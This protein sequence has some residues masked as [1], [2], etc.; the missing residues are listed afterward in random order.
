M[1]QSNDKAAAMAS[2]FVNSTNRHVFLTGKAGTGKTTF[3]RDISRLTHKNTIVAAPTGIA[4]IN[5]EGVTLHSLFQLPFGAFIPSDHYQ[6]EQAPAFQLNTPRS[7][8]Q[9]LKMYASKRNLLKKLELLIID[10][11]SMVRADLLDAVD[12]VLRR[13]RRRQDMPFGGV[14]VLFIGD[15]QQLPPV[16]KEAEWQ[17]LKQY[18]PTMFF[19]GAQVLQD[20][21][22]LYIELEKIYR[23]TDKEFIGVLNHLRD[24]QMTQQDVDTLNRYYKPGFSPASGDRY[25]D[26]DGYVYLTT[27]NYKA[28]RVNKDEL[29]KLPAGEFKYNAE[30][31]GTF[32]AHVYPVD[33]VLVL[34]K[35]AQVMF[36]KNDPSGEGQFF[37]GKIGKVE[38][39]ND[40]G[41]KVAFS[42]GA[43]SVWVEKYTWE[44]KRYTLNKKNNE[45]EEKKV[46][47]FVHFPIKLAWAI[48]VHKSQGLT[49]EKAIID[50]SQAFAAGQVYVALSRLTSLKGLVLTSPFRLKD[51]PQDAALQEFAGLKRDTSSLDEQ[52]QSAS[53][54]YLCE[55]VMRAFDFS[56]LRTEFDYHLHTYT[57][58]AGRSEKQ[59]S[60]DW[61]KSIY[62][63]LKP[64]KQVGDKFLKQLNRILQ[65]VS[66]KDYQHL[67]ERVCAAKNY[68]EPIL[69]EFSKK[70]AKHVAELT[71]QK[72]GVKQYIRELQD[73]DLMV[74][75]Q[76]QKIYKSISLI[77][78]FIRD[79]ELTKV[80]VD[81]PPRRDVV[82]TAGVSKKKAKKK[83]KPDTKAVTLQMFN[84]GK[85]I[86]DIAVERSLAVSTIA[87][88]LAW[89]IEQGEID[90]KQLMPQSVIDEILAAFKKLDTIHLS[91]VKKMLNHKY[92]YGQLKLVAAFLN[93][94]QLLD[95]SEL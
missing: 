12:A 40:S 75:G 30:V 54:T 20:R 45:I 92:D 84:N 78:A 53:T 66:S 10:E 60:L 34:K 50:V 70:I 25:G 9:Q 11:V 7:L 13:V 36:I 69:N 87:S 65:T 49:F 19:F 86:K 76:L 51:M 68:F 39:L 85:T 27:H 37:N 91:P 5:A 52:L 95:K 73:L 4:A 41:I 62:S 58:D 80:S 35:K 42:D 94:R 61:A 44:N 15:L 24:N 83:D 6:G 93:H 1:T 67:Q 38:A 47:A 17:V 26:G 55:E 79:T 32:D 72:K 82:L 3:L 59:K 48:T 8:H 64:V 43:P 33:P 90:I 74:Y 29:Q 57:K 77:D 14:Q 71:T 81:K 22:L 28:D 89:W 56:G 63:D 31:E 88:H 2:K 23:Q 21:Q 18:Y 16:V 46:G